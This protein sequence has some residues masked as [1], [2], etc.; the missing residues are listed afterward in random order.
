AVG[1]WGITRLWWRT[2][3]D[4]GT[5][6]A[7][8]HREDIRGGRFRM[9]GIVQDMRYTARRLLRAPVFTVGVIALLAIG[10]G[11][12]TSVFTLVDALILRPPPWSEPERVVHVYQDSDDGDP[13]ANSFPATQDMRTYTDVFSGVAAT[14]RLISVSWDGP[15]GPTPVAIEYTTSEY[16]RVLGLDVQRGRWFSSEHDVVGG[17]LAAVVSAAT[18]RGRFGAAPDVLGRT[19]ELNGQ[20]VTII[21][22]GPEGLTGTTTPL[23]T[24]FWL[25]V[26][27]TP[28]GGPYQVANLERRSDHWYSALARLQ[29]GVSVDQAQA[30]M[31]ALAVRLAEDYPEYNQGRDITVFPS[32]S[33]HMHPSADGDLVLVGGLLSAIA[34]AVLLLT[35]ANLANLLL[36]R[37]LDRSG[38]MAVRSALGAARGR[39][40]R[41]FLI[42]SAL[43]AIAGSVGGLVLTR[44]ALAAVPALPLADVLGGDPELHVDLRVI[45]FTLALMVVTALLFGLAPGIRSARTDVSRALRDDRRGASSG[46]GTLGLRSVL[47][48]VQVGASLVL[49]LSTGLMVR[50]LAALQA[51][52][53]GV[54][55]DRVA[56]LRLDWNR[57][58]MSDEELQ[59]SVDVLRD[60]LAALPGVDA[61]AMSS[62]LPAQNFGSTTTEIEGYTPPAGTS[63]VEMP[64]GVVSDGYFETLGVPLIEGRVFGPDDVLGDDFSIVVSEGTAQRFWGDADPIGRR[65]RGQGSEAWTRRVVGVVADVPVTDVGEPPTPMMYLST[66]QRLGA[67]SYV[68]AR[69]S[70]DPASILGSLRN[71]V[72]AWMPSLAVTGQGTLASHFGESLSTPRFAAQAMSAFSVLALILAGLGIYAVVS[73]TVARRAPELG[74]RIALG[75]ER[76]GVVRMV[77]L[78]ISRVVGLGLAGGLLVALLLSSRLQ[79]ILFGVPVL[80]PLVF[81]GAIAALVVVAWI[82]AWLPARRAARYDP[83]EALRVT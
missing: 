75:A 50:S 5:N 14:S 74:I 1:W 80:D 43:L 72:E 16:M 81:G 47:V 34:L 64:F 63:A 46:R 59:A 7:A 6:A 65:M 9:T 44:A 67:P 33:V 28:V 52:D 25:S 73:F 53:V 61:V 40:G 31:S 23:V 41:L 4:A 10:I 22:I 21:G 51:I 45:L 56:F 36:L 3:V 58:G 48:S 83:V 12:N 57:A 37:G 32:G 19:I 68:V 35:C 77:V 78:E 20:P 11:A 2:L 60:R 71:E 70:R 26:S 30:A 27:S 69:T 13:N 39:V 29:P 66:R 62:R 38:E 42:E 76:S 8:L 79:G 55:V 49:V 18:W 24:D 15:D 17:P 54:D 82:A